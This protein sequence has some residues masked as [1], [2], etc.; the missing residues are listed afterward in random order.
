MLPHE[1]AIIG[2]AGAGGAAALTPP[3]Y[4]NGSASAIFLFN[5]HFASPTAALPG[6]LSAGELI[7]CQMVGLGNTTSGAVSGFTP[8]IEID[9]TN[10]YQ[11]L[12][13]KVAVGG[14]SNPTVTTSGNACAVVFTVWQGVDTSDPFDGVTPTT[15]SDMTGDPVTIPAITPNSAG[16]RI[17]GF[18]MAA[19]DLASDAFSG[20][21]GDF[22]TH[23]DL[24]FDNNFDGGHLI[25]SQ[26]STTTSPRGTYSAG[27]GGSAS[28]NAISVV[29][30]GL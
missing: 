21:S 7:I 17:V 3:T 6:S 23:I 15:T 28:R 5:S 13:Y 30:K 18:A 14:D 4:D 8:L 19:N 12:F 10:T 1:F 24:V 2:A 27:G 26:S 22:A 25:G 9:G 20:T 29:L 11:R 16:T